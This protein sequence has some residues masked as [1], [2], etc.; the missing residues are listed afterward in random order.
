[1]DSASSHLDPDY[2]PFLLGAVILGSS[3]A[4]FNTK[5]RC[6]FSGSSLD[7]RCYC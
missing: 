6:H 4:L 1:L 3:T 2:P 7:F 5:L